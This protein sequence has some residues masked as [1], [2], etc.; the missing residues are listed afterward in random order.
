LSY[1]IDVRGL[2]KSGTGTTTASAAFRA[3]TNTDLD[4]RVDSADGVLALGVI[5]ANGVN[6]LNKSGMGT[7]ILP[8]SGTFSG[9]TGPTRPLE[10]TIVVAGSNALQNSTLDLSAAGRGL[11]RFDLPYSVAGV[12]P[13]VQ[14]GG[15]SGTRD[16]DFGRIGGAVIGNNNASTAYSGILSGIIS[17]G[18]FRKIG[19]GTLSLSGSSTFAGV[20]SIDSGAVE[21]NSLPAAGQASPLGTGGTI[22]LGSGSTAGTLRYT[23][24]GETTN[25]A[26]NLAGTSGGGEIDASGSGPLQ[27]TSPLTAAATA[28]NLTL[29]GSSTADNSLA[30]IPSPV[31]DVIKTGPGL[32]RLVGASSYTGQLRVLDGTVVVGSN[33]GT[34]TSIEGNSPFG[35]ATGAA[36]LPVVG[37]GTAVSGTAAML[38]APGVEVWR[39][40]SVASGGSQVVVLGGTGSGYSLVGSLATL[41]IGRDVTLQAG[42]SGTVEFAGTWLNTAGGGTQPITFNVGSANN[43]G[44]VVFN[45]SLPVLTGG[46]NVRQGTLRLDYRDPTDGN[47]PISFGTPVTLGETATSSTLVVNNIEQS[48]ASLSFQGVGSEATTSGT[49]RLRLFNNGTASAVVNVTG[50]GHVFSA[51]ANLDDA[52]TFTVDPASRLRVTGVIAT[53]SGGPRTLTKA[54]SGTLELSATNTYTGA[55]QV[56]AGTLALTGSGS[57]PD[58]GAVNVAASNATFDI[59]GITASGLTIGSLS[60]STGSVVTL[61]GRNLTAGDATSTTFAG[62][63]GGTGGLTKAGAGVFTLSGSNTY[64]GPTS[65]SAGRLAVDGSLASAVTVQAGATLGGSGRLAGNLTGDGLI[66]PGNS[67]GILTVDGQITPTGT[68]AFAFEFSGTAPT[69]G[70]ASASVNDVLRLTN[71]DPFAS[72]LTSSNIVNIYFDVASLAGGDTFLGGF[73]SDRTSGQLGFLAE[74]GS[75]TYQFYVLGSGSG[76]ATTYNGKSYYTLA[77]YDPSL[78]GVTVSVVTVPTADYAGGDVTNGQVTQF[79]IVPEPTALA[80]AAL[81]IAAA[82]WAARR[83]M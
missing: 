57:L 45:S 23:G 18:T 78:S 13:S 25:R 65:I 16:L 27:F 62:G 73:Y 69:W 30:V 54:G 33:V 20:T 68:T 12:A 14:L 79:V 71:P 44:T 11:V 51:A 58:T 1:T 77:Q 74:I 21:T 50:T 48:L 61:G 83:R 37:D 17:T 5:V 49:G 80:L 6:G 2:L 52:T 34:N 4:I 70:S 47:G 19:T 8:A 60:G 38:L 55:T 35:S 64:S 46:V 10:G 43:A 56:N 9:P 67:P 7:L 32:W 75:P 40:F 22:N 41:R 76:T 82:A 42:T 53:G 15:L 28:K 72:G 36:F 3:P 31:A 63:I 24:S 29:A 66:A 59:S 26:I 39:G 81:G